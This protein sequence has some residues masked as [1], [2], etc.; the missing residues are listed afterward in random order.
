MLRHRL[1]ALQAT[2]VWDGAT[3]ILI[4]RGAGRQAGMKC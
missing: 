4:I 2:D 1:K 3:P